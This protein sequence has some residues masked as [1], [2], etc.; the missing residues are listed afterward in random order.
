M[1]K[2]GVWRQR[3]TQQTEP[4]GRCNELISRCTAPGGERTEKKK[5]NKEGTKPTLMPWHKGTA[6][7]WHLAALELCL[8]PYRGEITQIFLSFSFPPGMAPPAQ[9]RSLPHLWC[10][11]KFKNQEQPKESNSNFEHFSAISCSK[12]KAGSQNKAKINGLKLPYF[13]P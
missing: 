4:P 5:E 12:L 1:L 11:E 2:A 6:S 8:S 7:S 13:V 10:L 3:N 9:P